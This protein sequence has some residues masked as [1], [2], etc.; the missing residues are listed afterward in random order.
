MQNQKMEV[1][2]SKLPFTMIKPE[3][4]IE[5]DAL[6]IINSNSSGLKSILS[7]Q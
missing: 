7:F 3:F 6:D 1:S 4:V 2:G 5:I